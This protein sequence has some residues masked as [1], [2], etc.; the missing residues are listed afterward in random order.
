M[1]RFCWK[2]QKTL[3][4]KQRQSADKIKALYA[5]E[6]ETILHSLEPI[7]IALTPLQIDNIITSSPAPKNKIANTSQS[8]SQTTLQP[9]IKRYFMVMVNILEPLQWIIFL[10]MMKLS[11][12]Q[13]YD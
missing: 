7:N 1:L 3:T 6:K 10:Q 4:P 11:G 2:K 9:E 5:S 13:M 12:L 8:Q